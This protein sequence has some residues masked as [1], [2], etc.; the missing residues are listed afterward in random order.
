LIYHS[1]AIDPRG[2][3]YEID[4]QQS[5]ALV[6]YGRILKSVGDRY[7]DKAANVISNLLTLGHTRIKD[8]REAYFPPQNTELEDSDDEPVVNGARKRAKT[9]GVKTDDEPL[10]NGDGHANGHTNG[11][12]GVKKRPRPDDDVDVDDTQPSKQALDNKTIQSTA[13]LDDIIHRLMRYGWIMKVEDTQYLGPGDLHDIARQDAWQQISFGN[14]PTGTKE[15]DRA[16]FVMLQRKREIRDGW[17]TVPDF[18]TRKRKPTDPDFSRSMKRTK[19]TSASDW[20]DT[21]DEVAVLDGDLIV[22]VNPDKATVAMRTDILVRLVRQRLGNIPAKIYQ[23]MLRK[24]EVHQGR[25]YEEWP[26]PPPADPSVGVDREMDNR[27]LVTAREVAKALDPRIDVFEGLDPHTIVRVTYSTSQ[28]DKKGNI[29]PPIDPFKLNWDEKTKVVDRHIKALADDPFHFVTWHARN[30]YSQWHVEFEEIAQ[31]LIQHEIE[32]T[33]AAGTA[34]DKKY[35][36]KLVRA[37]KKKGKLDERQMSNAMMMPPGEVRSVVN[38][39]TV[40]GFVQ[41]Q[42]IPK[43]ERRE[44]KHSIHLIWFD[45]QRAREQLLHDTYKAMVRTLQRTVVEKERVQELLSKAERTDVVG[46]EEK[47][48]SQP[49]LTALKRWKDVQGKLLLQLFR[50]DELVAALRDFIGPLTSA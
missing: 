45:R 36:V 9:N 17:S 25:C 31:S 39:L 1:A 21:R 12:N 49:E 40:R 15:K 10:T 4:W 5:Y 13:E 8:L 29:N 7:G 18:P 44:A 46:N 22:R 6:R 30:G 23:L 14:P 38:A 41:T 35:G 47:W 42:E 3:Y 26:D 48:L 24:I 33:I 19:L 43:V 27:L 37:L 50:Q 28:V 2:T 20:A 34:Q 11:T 32:N 16:A